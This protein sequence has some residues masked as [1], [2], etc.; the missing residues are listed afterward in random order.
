MSSGIN[1]E[2]KKNRKGEAMKTSD[3]DADNSGYNYVDQEIQAGDIEIHPRVQRYFDERHASRILS[4]FDPAILRP[5]AVIPGS[6]NNKYLLVDGQ[7]GFWAAKQ[8]LGSGWERQNIACRLYTVGGLADAARLCDLLN[9]NV[10]SWR[11]ID[12]FLNQVTGN[13]AEVLAILKIVHQYG[14]KIESTGKMP[15]IILAVEAVRSIYRRDDGKLLDRTISFLHGTWGSASDAYDQRILRGT[16]D[17]LSRYGDK[18]DGNQFSHKIAK[19]LRP[20]N[21]IGDARAIARLERMSVPK[22]VAHRLVQ[23]YNVRMRKN[24]LGNLDGNV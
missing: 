21:L 17:F 5:L 10:K 18:I 19:S 8:W 13:V 14:L 23:E 16:A 12:K 11:A 24:R 9:S 1:A 7:H 3:K 22:A 6:R 2:H 15:G 4:K 20:E